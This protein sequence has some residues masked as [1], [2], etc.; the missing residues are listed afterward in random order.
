MKKDNPP[1]IGGCTIMT[2][3]FV[4]CIAVF[5]ILSLST[6]GANGR[7]VRHGLDAV[8]GYYEAENE[9]NE[10]LAALREGQI[11]AGV[12]VKNGTYSYSCGIS[13]TMRLEAEI[14]LSGSE[15]EVLRWQSVSSV[16]WQNDDSIKV[17]DGT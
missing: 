1:L 11:P 2:I 4:L 14:R 7:L 15:Y 6:A 3:L 13:D 17:W 10:I 9:A 8:E 5:S 12:T 16:D